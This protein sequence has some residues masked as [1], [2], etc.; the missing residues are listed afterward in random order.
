MDASHFGMFESTDPLLTRYMGEIRRLGLDYY[1]ICKDALAVEPRVAAEQ[2]GVPNASMAYAITSLEE[3]QLEILGQTGG[4]PYEISFSVRMLDAVQRPVDRTSDFHQ[5][6]VE[7]SSGEKF[8][9]RTVSWRL[10]EL[11]W[12]SDQWLLCRELLRAD[13]ALGSV[14]FGLPEEGAGI[15]FMTSG[16]LLGLALESHGQLRF[17]AAV[18]HQL[19]T[20]FSDAKALDQIVL[21]F[22]MAT[23]STNICSAAKG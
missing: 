8:G 15:E 13:R 2:F 14:I 11:M 5:A 22:R 9:R 3:D 7:A 20:V 21:T 19:S 4:L 16:E 12:R 23:G 18:P 10:R 1:R 6:I 17:P